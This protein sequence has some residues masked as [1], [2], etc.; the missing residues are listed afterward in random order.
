ML[1]KWIYW[2]KDYLFKF[3]FAFSEYDSKKSRV[4]QS[5][6]N[7]WQLRVLFLFFFFY[8]MKY[9]LQQHCRT[10]QS[11]RQKALLS[12][13]GLDSFE[14][15]S[16]SSRIADCSRQPQARLHI[17]G[18]GLAAQPTW[19]VAE[20]QP[21]LRYPFHKSLDRWWSSIELHQLGSDCNKNFIL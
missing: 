14:K 11:C 9:L 19:G 6:V 18:L 4:R 8:M 17:V 21:A 2:K 12:I 7:S 5:T 3:F 10:T 1:E 16:W 13:S 15:D 20:G